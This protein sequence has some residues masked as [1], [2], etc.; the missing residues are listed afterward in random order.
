MKYYI[1]FKLDQFWCTNARYHSSP[2][3]LSINELK[4]ALLCVP[5][6]I[7]KLSTYLS[8][9]SAK[10]WPPW[11]LVQTY[12]YLCCPLR[13]LK[14]PQLKISKLINFYYNLYLLYA[15]DIH[16]SFLNDKILLILYVYNH[17]YYYL[18]RSHNFLE[19]FISFFY[20]PL[21]FPV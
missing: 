1:S 3:I 20:S 10:W 12:A 8:S 18:I 4:W 2:P 6:Q 7:L 17:A 9:Y 16:N 19:Q 14:L 5:L 13:N 21:S 11:A 15:T